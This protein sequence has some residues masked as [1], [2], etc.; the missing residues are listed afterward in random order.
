MDKQKI[1]SI[2]LPTSL[3]SAGCE[4]GNSIRAK[5]ASSMKRKLK[6]SKICVWFQRKEPFREYRDPENAERYIT[7]KTCLTS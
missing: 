2:I 5:C 4:V 1:Y 3:V 6:F 7:H